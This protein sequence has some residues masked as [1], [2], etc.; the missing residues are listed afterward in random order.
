MKKEQ[1]RAIGARLR[2]ARRAA[3]LSQK[4]VAT[5]LGFSRQALSSWECGEHEPR[6]EELA[7]LLIR[8]GASSD[9]V[10]LGVNTVPASL[11]AVLQRVAQIDA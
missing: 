4:E 3:R 5:E 7:K 1:C 8:Y 9:Y 6:L 2:E 11:A 10:L